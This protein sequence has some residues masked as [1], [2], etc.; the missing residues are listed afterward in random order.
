MHLMLVQH[1]QVN[2]IITIAILQMGKR[3]LR[4]ASEL[5]LGFEPALKLGF[6]VPALSLWAQLSL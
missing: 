4:A 5:E 3:R 1:S 2:A 6:R